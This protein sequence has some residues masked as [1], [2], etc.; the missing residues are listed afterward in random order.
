MSPRLVPVLVAL[1]AGLGGSMPAAAQTVTLADVVVSEAAGAATFTIAL[2][3]SGS[4]P[5]TVDWAIADVSAT[6]GRDYL[7]PFSG[8]VTFGAGEVSQAVSVGV[9][10]DT[11]SEDD[12]AFAL[13]LSNPVG[14]RLDRAVGFATIL[15]DDPVTLSV[16]DVTVN[17]GN[18]GSFAAYVTVFL[19]RVLDQPVSFQATTED[20]TA[21]AGA[22]Y[23]ARSWT[24]SI[25]PGRHATTLPVTIRS[26]TL[27]EDDETILVDLSNVSGAAIGDGQAEITIRDDEGEPRPS[28]RHIWR[29]AVDGMANIRG[30]AWGA[31]KWVVVDDGG[32][33]WT[34][35][36]AVS[37]TRR[38]YADELHLPLRDVAFADGLF[39]AVGNAP[40]LLTSPNGIDWTT[41]RFPS[42][43]GLVGVARSEST[44]VAVGGEVY[45]SP[46]AVTWTLRGWHGVYD[47]AWGKGL[48][49]GLADPGTLVTSP[50]GITWTPRQLPPETEGQLLTRVTFDGSRFVAAGRVFLYSDDGI[51]WQSGSVPGGWCCQV[52]GLAAGHGQ[53]VAVAGNSIYTS[54]DGV[55]F[56]QQ[57]SPVFG[58]GEGDR[59]QA[60]ASGQ[61]G[62]LAVGDAGAMATSSTDGLVWTNRTPATSRTWTGLAWNGS[63]LCAVGGAGAAATSPD[64]VSW[65]AQSGIESRP[66][67]YDV[68]WTGSEFLAVGTPS[69][70][71]PGGRLWASS[72]CDSWTDRTPPELEW[73]G[74]LYDVLQAG[75]L[76]VAVGGAWT[77]PGGSQ[78]LVFTSPDGVTWTRADAALPADRERTLAAVAYGGG[79]FVALPQYLG[80]QA[81][82]QLPGYGLTSTDGVTWTPFT[83]PSWQ[84]SPFVN[85]IV[86]A[87]GQFL[88]VGDKRW[89]SPDGLSWTDRGG[90]AYPIDAAA[91]GDGVFVALGAAR[92]E[93]SVD[94]SAWD[95]PT[96][97]TNHTQYAAV[98]LPELDRFVAAGAGAITYT[99]GVEP[100][101]LTLTD[102]SASE[103]TGTITFTA[104]L[105]ATSD[106]SVSVDCATSDFTAKALAD[107]TAVSGT[108]EIPAGQM[109]GSFTVS[110]VDDGES[111][112]NETFRVALSRPVGATL[113][114]D[115]LVGTILDDEPL[116]LSIADTSVVEG[117]AGSTSAAF[118]V[119]LSRPSA[120]AVTVDYATSNG[121]ATAGSDY[122]SRSG[123]LS[124]SPGVTLR[125]LEV[126]VLGDIAVEGNETFFVDLGNPVGAELADG[127]AVGTILDDDAGAPAPEARRTWRVARLGMPSM[128]AVAASAT[129]Q[130]LAGDGGAIYTSSD[131]GSWTRRANPDPTL[132]NLRGGV[133][134][135]GRFVLVGDCCVGSGAAVVLTST[136]GAAWTLRPTTMPSGGQALY[137]VG[138]GGGLYVAVGSGG[139]IMTS[140][141]A[142]T[143]TERSSPTTQE[144]RS[145]AYGNDRFVAVGLS[146]TVLTSGDGSAWAAQPVGLGNVGAVT[147]FGGEFLAVAG[148]GIWASSDGAAWSRRSDMQFWM[149]SWSGIAGGAGTVVAAGGDPQRLD[150]TNAAV[151]TSTD[152]FNWTNVAVAYG[153]PGEAR[154]FRTVGYGPAGFVAAGESGTLYVST[155]GLSWTSRA[156]PASRG[157][158]A[159][160]HDDGTRYCAVGSYG[161]VARSTDGVEWSNE[162]GPPFPYY[163][164]TWESVAAGAGV[165]VAVGQREAVA[166]SADCASWT[167][168]N[169]TRGPLFGDHGGSF[170]DVTRGPGL[171]VA[172]GEEEWHDRGRRAL[173]ATSPDGATWTR[174]SMGLADDLQ[175]SLREV[176]WGAGRYLAVGRHGT[177]YE[178]V[179]LTSPDGLAW[180]QVP[181]LDLGTEDVRDLGF[182]HGL[183]VALGQGRIWT[184]P[185]GQAWTLRQAPSWY[186]SVASGNGLLVA[187]D[188]C[189]QVASSADGLTWLPNT[190]ATSQNLQGAAYAPSFD[191]FVG[192]G[193]STIVYTDGPA[194]PQV[195]VAV[196]DT[197][198]VEGDSGSTVASFPVRLSSASSASIA[199]SWRTSAYTATS[200][201]DFTAGPGT[202]VIPAG[203]T[204]GA[205]EVPVLGDTLGEAD[206]QFEV[207][208]TG[209]EGATLA[210][211]HAFAT[212]TDNDLPTL[213]AFATEAPEG[214]SGQGLLFFPLSL[215]KPATQ[216]VAVTYA[217][218]DGTA[219]AG[220]DYTAT[221]GALT[222]P[223]GAS[224]SAVVVPIE[225]DTLSEGNETLHL[226]ITVL[227]GATLRTPLVTGTIL[228]DETGLPL[229]W[230][231]ARQGMGNVRGLAHGAGRFVAVTD[232]GSIWTS[233]NGISWTERTPDLGYRFLRAVTYGPF[234]FVAVGNGYYGLEVVTSADGLTWTPRLPPLPATSRVAWT[235]I[236]SGDDRLVTVGGA[237]RA[238]VSTDSV[239]W[240][241]HATGT[242]NVLN[243]VVWGGGLFVAV[244]AGRTVLTSTDGVSW[245]PQ[246]AP[247]GMPAVLNA[248]AWTGSQFVAV[249]N[250]GGVMTSPDGEVWTQHT[251]GTSANLFALTWTGAGLVA[252]S[253]GA[254]VA[255][256]PDGVAWTLRSLPGP[257]PGVRRAPRAVAA[258]SGLV[259][260]AGFSGGVFTST[261]GSTWTSA[262]LAESRHL[263]SVAWDGTRYCAAGLAGAFASSTDGVS[264]TNQT[265][266]AGLHG[267]GWY[268][269]A[270][271][272]GQFVAVG[273]S[274]EIVSSSDCVTWTERNAGR[275]VSDPTQ[276]ISG[277]LQD[278]TFADGQFVAVG[279][280]VDPAT[281]LAN[282]LLAT[283]PD[284]LVWTERPTGLPGDAERTLQAIAWGDDRYV[285]IGR[286]SDGLTVDLLTSPDA[287]TW[288]PWPAP[289]L[290]GREFINDLAWGGGQFVAAGSATWTSP[291]GVSWS[292]QPGFFQSLNGVAQG[293]GRFVTV[294][295]VGGL[296]ATADGQSWRASEPPSMQTYLGLAYAGDAFD[297]FVAVGD[298]TIAYTLP[299]APPTVTVAAPNGGEKVFNGQPYLITWT[300]SGPIARFSVFSSVDGGATWSVVPG[301]SELPGTAGS[302]HWDLP[303]PHTNEGRVRV[304]AQDAWGNA[305]EDVSD[306][307]FRIVSGRPSITLTSPSTALTWVVGATKQITW[308]HNL[309]V[310]SFKIELSRD[311]GTSWSVIAPSV[312]GG[313]PN[314]G[315]FDWT[316]TGPPTGQARVRVSWT[317]NETVRDAS[318][319]SFT[320]ASPVV[321]VTAP[322]TAVS[323]AEGSPRTITWTH[324]LGTGTF[325]RIELSRDGGINYRAEDLVCA[326]CP[327]TAA[328]SGSYAWTVPAGPTRAARIRVTWA[329]SA[330]ASDVSDVDFAIATPSLSLTSPTA[331]ATW[332]VGSAQTVRWTHN[333]GTG[334]SVRIELSRDGGATY[335]T[336]VTSYPNSS[337]TAGTYGWKVTGPATAQARLRVSWTT[338]PTVGDVRAFV[339]GR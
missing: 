145:V 263:R 297:R 246:V 37:W 77:Q 141:D 230:R 208:L 303:G 5:I 39:V 96:L 250:A 146:S 32:D 171:F 216:D 23:D 66:W 130:V 315:T 232:A 313:G 117:F 335:T 189:G 329:A 266:P 160:A 276:G 213:D 194:S 299:S 198:V 277:F 224:G 17:E 287:V 218:A 168:R 209:A 24:G 178:A 225:G 242:T 292:K 116:A 186:S 177:T 291:D 312:P 260:I 264:W 164:D 138:H 193:D 90:W 109:R 175:I 13:R 223:A 331:G 52:D 41:F 108:L 69:T 44:W 78:A 273:D 190:P 179:V 1:A 333:L 131:G 197:T 118:A 165:F 294:G 173:L 135:D 15:D 121:T 147:F 54:L 104:T 306:A 143:W 272:N 124:F 81:P 182:G 120:S 4:A 20:G 128:S 114:D 86:Y 88:A 167:D 298:S 106:Q 253:G 337:D 206:E 192:V 45:T 10:S 284:G 210:N 271:G 47:V 259:V 235:S 58:V 199:V 103:S 325:V 113:A 65:T 293:G 92:V 159:V 140:P 68:L 254:T 105:S 97:A 21:T 328:T 188:C 229:E 290:D 247:A 19:S 169:P 154:N 279:W 222:I 252:A 267:F 301:C 323:W 183:F 29:R 31:G 316:V 62:F 148:S 99:E 95:Q 320:I 255:T 51:N 288:T 162:V 310:A 187:L 275:L 142:T 234:G 144:L 219:A 283:S 43:I 61:G 307:F 125:V 251:S 338:R 239:T 311:G 14:A 59:Y 70:G 85:A 226:Q 35:P 127:R 57:S 204:S 286:Q 133:Y 300:A 285:A 22:D 83:S 16:A 6:A 26:D 191:R 119:R 63:S 9:V 100:P 72:D 217:T 174:R 94:G 289:A 238:A 84:G 231:K 18:A 268:S 67:L 314:T 155:D 2:T 122:Q 91:A 158:N 281:Q 220:R 115:L 318:R 53:F 132:R 257:A 112:A 215:T 129:V 330:A 38:E 76:L 304:T 64:G 211:T 139:R 79:R 296:L 202:V 233:P 136:D 305:V 87:S 237:G 240:A 181:T 317:A 205:I 258:G 8:T 48:F 280:E 269:V 73:N 3:S 261:D 28:T 262:T 12:E 180:A 149:A 98:Y 152:G 49:V 134:A 214:Q 50:D 201:V 163:A 71:G 56:T 161:A 324:N 212:I 111:E 82:G 42:S 184:S 270:W 278:V 319:V 274:A 30:A 110:L 282:V 322:N 172:V 40:I 265:G 336:L 244:G 137:A 93:E 166:T 196:G 295:S 60:V 308:N 302:C 170:F 34:S 327:N 150:M 75:S 102:A 334:A 11:E 207:M 7:G 33:I 249:G 248:V 27:V 200:G 245:T 151:L 241:V 243:G 326:S 195:A 185:D 80:G 203:S 153:A 89:T 126:P 101:V 46:D 74:T 25:G 156:L 157:L 236:A 332:K 256:S 123:T 221:S 339:I 55:T 228:D 107:Y 36:D 321:T 309:A 176:T 227:S